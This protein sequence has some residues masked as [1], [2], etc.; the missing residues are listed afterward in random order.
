M[1]VGNVGK[2]WE[3]GKCSEKWGGRWPAAGRQVA[4]C[5]VGR[6]KAG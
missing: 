5:L 2:W 3:P 4:V 1:V 6:Q